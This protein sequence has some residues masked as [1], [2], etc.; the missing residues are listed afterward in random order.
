M[1]PQQG[2]ICADYIIIGPAI[3]IIKKYRAAHV[4]LLSAETPDCSCLCVMLSVPGKPEE[5]DK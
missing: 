4:L 1:C 3:T 2:H 5:T